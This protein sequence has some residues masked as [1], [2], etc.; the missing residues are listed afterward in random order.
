MKQRNSRLSR[1]NRWSFLAA[2]LSLAFL[3]SVPAQAQFAL[4]KLSEDNFNNNDSRHRTEVEPHTFAYG[5]TIVAAFQVARVFAG[6]GADIGFATSKDAGTT[7]TSGYLPGL[8]INYQGGTFTAASDAAVAYDLKH[9]VWLISSLPIVNNNPGNVAVSRSTDGLTWGSP[10][11]VDSSGSDDKNWIVC[12][13]N[14]LSR[15]YG[16]CY[17][18]WDEPALG[19]LIFMSVSTDGGLTWG[20][21]KMTA[22]QAGGLGG[23]P[24]VQPNGTVI[25]PID[26]FGGMISFRST[27]GGATWSRTFNI[28]FQ[29]FRGQDGGLRSPGLPSAAIDRNGKVYVVWP[30]CRFRTGCSTDDIVMSTS[31]DGMNWTAPVRIPIDPLTSTVDHFIPGL[32]IDASVVGFAGAKTQIAM[33]YYYYP[34]AN[35]G[36]SCQLEVGYTISRD[37]GVNWTPG[38][39]LAGPMSLTWLP[40]SQN[41]LM[42]ADYLSVAYAN[43]KPFGVFAVAFAPTNGVLNEAMYTTK[44]ALIGSLDGPVFNSAGEKPVPDAKGR[45][46]WRYYDDEGEYPIPPSKQ[47]PPPNR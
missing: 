9:N 20:P 30:D 11:I 10:I 14:R 47:I 4:V 40:A 28:G 19:D 24:L 26:G 2:A 27:D 33:T 12:D 18:E 23:Q 44:T 34:K 3:L 21:K 32:G 37:G 43:G 5:S 29:N 22:D 13:N 17:S 1:R 8:T 38:V 35:C 46:V 25:V 31:T 45:Y 7:W 16:N 39:N 6:G 42:V 15:F 41:G 36:N